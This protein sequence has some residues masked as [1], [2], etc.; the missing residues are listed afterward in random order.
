MVT[1]SSIR[2]AAVGGDRRAR[3]GGLQAE[4]SRL[5]LPGAARFRGR[6][7]QARDEVEI[8]SR[9]ADFR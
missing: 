2:S 9:L 4:R 7:H 8:R 5:V 3:T 6:P 1:R